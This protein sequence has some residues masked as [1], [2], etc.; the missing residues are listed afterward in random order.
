MKPLFDSEHFTFIGDSEDR[1]FVNC[2]KCSG[3]AGIEMAAAGSLV[4]SVTCPDC[5]S[6]RKFTFVNLAK[7]AS[8][9]HSE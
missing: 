8:A 3:Q 6:H 9:R 7:A 1:I 5:G 2:R 4:I